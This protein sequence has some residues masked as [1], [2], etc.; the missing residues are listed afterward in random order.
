MSHLSYFNNKSHLGR[1]RASEK[2]MERMFQL[3]DQET[4][5]DVAL[6]IIEDMIELVFDPEEAEETPTGIVNDRMI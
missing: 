2:N 3:K 6:E 5:Q 1:S 4:S